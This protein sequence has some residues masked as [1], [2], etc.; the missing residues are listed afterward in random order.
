MVASSCDPL[1]VVRRGLHLPVA[2]TSAI[3]LWVL[4]TGVPAGVGVCGLL[5]VDWVH[6]DTD[7]DSV[8]NLN[9]IEIYVLLGHGDLSLCSR[10]H[11]PLRALA[12]PLHHCIR[13]AIRSLAIAAVLITA[14]LP[15]DSATPYKI[16]PII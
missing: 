6:R 1:V 10:L 3:T 16:Q 11:E 4:G 15:S 5:T 8:N 12:S 7:M 2:A 14:S 9:V 13:P